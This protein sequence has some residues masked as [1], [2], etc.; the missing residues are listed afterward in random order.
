MKLRIALLA[1]LLTSQPA[2]AE[3]VREPFAAQYREDFDSGNLE[4]PGLAV[5]SGY[6][7]PL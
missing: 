2:F 1:L 5:T 6:L 3:T 4:A 7:L